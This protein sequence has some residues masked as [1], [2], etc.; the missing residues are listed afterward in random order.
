[1]R[2]RVRGPRAPF[3]LSGLVVAPVA[4]SGCSILFCSPPTVVAVEIGVS[5]LSGRVDLLSGPRDCAVVV[6][7]LVLVVSGASESA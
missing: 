6:S 4:L 2:V 7:V 3:G 1:M 5:L